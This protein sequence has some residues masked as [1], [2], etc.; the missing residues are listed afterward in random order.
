MRAARAEATNH[1]PSTGP[2]GRAPERAPESSR[3]NIPSQGG[4]TRANA[5]GARVVTGLAGRRVQR[6]HGGCSGSCTRVHAVF[7][8]KRVGCSGCTAGARAAAP[9]LRRVGDGG[10]GARR[11]QCAGVRVQRAL[12]SRERAHRLLTLW[13]VEKSQGA[14]C[15]RLS[16]VRPCED[17]I[18]GSGPGIG[19]RRA[20]YC[21]GSE[22]SSCIPSYSGSRSYLHPRPLA[23]IGLA[24]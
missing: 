15:E 8:A 10:S 16:E 7:H 18:A 20:E 19:A 14:V 5:R 21:G 4:C 3:L 17:E 9:A 13:L 23:P 1:T 11:V 12:S 24:S 6:V 2:R 22:H